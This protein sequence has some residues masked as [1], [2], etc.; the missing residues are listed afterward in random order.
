MIL[1]SSSSGLPSSQ[2]VTDCKKNPG[3]VLIGHPFNPPHL[4]PLVEVVPH[5]ETSESAIA[6]AISFYKGLKKEP[7]LVKKETPGFIANRLQATVCQE[8]YSL[9][10]RGI[11]SAEDLGRSFS[12]FFRP[13]TV[14]LKT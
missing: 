10:S 6:T 3:R 11:I 9:V 2:F 1:A 12:F 5:P 13:S 8:A 7:V 14:V 4:V